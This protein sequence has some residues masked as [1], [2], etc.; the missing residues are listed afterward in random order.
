MQS[1]ESRPESQPA[2]KIVAAIDV[3][4]N[5]LRMVIA[6]VSS[7]GQIE[8]LERLQRAVR[9]GQDTFRRGRLGGQAMRAAVAVLR[10]YKHLLAV[11][12]AERVRAVATT[13][14]REAVNADTFLDRVFMASGLQLEVI[15]TSEES[16]LTVS[17]VRQA[18]GGALG[19]DR[20]QALITEVG[21]GSTLL[22]VLENGEIANSQS[23]RLG[24]IRLQEVLSTSDEPPERSADLLR[25]YIGKVIAS[26]R[27]SLP[28]KDVRS[29]VA[30]GGDARFAARQ[31][32]KPTASADLYTV[33]V[34][35]FD[36]LVNRCGRCSAEELG[37]RHGLPFADAETLVPALFVYQS[38]L[39]STGSGQMIVSH[40]SM[41]DGLLLELAQHVTGQEDESLAQGVI[42]SAMALAEKYG[43]DLDHARNVAELS[44]RLFDELSAD[45]GLGD[46]ERL[47]LRVAALLHEV[48]AYVGIAAH[49]KH[50]Y[51][52][53]SHSEIFGLNRNEIEIVAH[54]ARYHR[55]SP[56]KP[57]HVGYVSLPRETR[58]VVNKL[59][60]ILRVADALSRGYLHR[61]HDLRLE[62][63]DD[64]LII[65]IVG[66]G[67]LTLEQ[68]AMAG[69]GDLFEDIY[70]MGIR[71][72]EA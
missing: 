56:P 10:D 64:D 40:V 44:L 55:R 25:H 70:G 28:L 18:V 15:G 21:G 23:L 24:S 50:S 7:E 66:A 42:H 33:D 72:E 57:S 67:D 48:G 3:G 68:R 26:T 27:A 69:K 65:Q 4:S 62:R 19:V 63:Q 14:V 52:L 17:A 35:E 11:Y 38:L 22:T 30:I 58:V 32:G 43:A 13:A 61:A 54:I 34:G 51:Y 29:F 36:Q 2:A 5:A 9:L 8:I 39:H 46:R 37:N 45:H 41:R 1:K 53:I 59:A 12:R 60:A 16:R 6:E 71:L 31:I 49:H 47:L 20:N